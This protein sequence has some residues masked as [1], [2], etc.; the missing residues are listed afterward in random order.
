M[1][2]SC[3]YERNVANSKV[4]LIRGFARFVSRNTVEVDGSVSYDTC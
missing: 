1:N 4:E 3:I 2:V